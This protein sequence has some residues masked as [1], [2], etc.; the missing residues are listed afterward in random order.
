[1]TISPML[2]IIFNRP[3]TT[4]RVMEAI[5]AARPPR[6]YIAADGP[7]DRPGEAERCERA[8]RI[9]TAV[10]WPCEVHK[11]LRDRNLGC[12]E[13]P[14]GAITWF[15]EHEE[16]G[17][18]LEDDC[19][20]AASFFRFCDELLARFREDQRV[21][22]ITGNNF[23]HDMGEYPY[24]YYFSKYNH[25]WGWASWRRAWRMYDADTALLP[26]F[27]RSRALNAMSLSPE[28]AEYWERCFES[29]YTGHLDAWDYQWTFCC[30]AQNG[31]TATP[32]VNLVS[33]IGFGPGATHTTDRTN[34]LGQ[35][36]T[37]ILQFPLDHPP[38]LTAHQGFD[39]FADRAMFGIH[40]QGSTTAIRSLPRRA[41]GKIFRRLQSG[42]RRALELAS[43]A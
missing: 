3:D 32:R 19:L 2:L 36:A 9:A 28:F 18:V 30:W 42:F 25:C 43:I 1:M 8:R 27:K 29:T 37:G 7:R 14:I 22:C 15:F 4:A 24:S 38:L 13:A 12:R 26:E 21:M 31:L 11:L 40:R 16:E 34:P 39:A 41:I 23:Q 10:D 20:P 17:I 5:R 6:L 33:N 35:M